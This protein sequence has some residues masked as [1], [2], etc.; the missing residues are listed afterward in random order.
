MLFRS[1]IF[2]LRGNPGG[3][4]SSVLNIADYFIKSN[5][6]IFRMDYLDGEVYTEKSRTKAI[7]DGEMI[8]LVDGNS[9]SASEV[10]TGILQDYER[11][12]VMGT[13]TYGKGIVQ[14]FFTLEDGGGLKVTIAHYY[15]P[16]GR[17]FH[18]V[19]ITPDY[20][21]T[22]PEEVLNGETK[23]TFDNDTQL[24]A[25]ITYLDRQIQIAD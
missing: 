3:L 7:F 9:A 17:D 10:M 14:S 8:L 2:D 18:G 12:T 22:L 23:L 19:G 25:A 11:A 15:S 16:L 13:K 5:L 20:E 21:V 1:L 6:L 4:L 24:Q